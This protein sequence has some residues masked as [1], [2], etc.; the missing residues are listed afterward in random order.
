MKTMK[1]T[2]AF[3]LAF[4]LVAG[5][6]PMTSGNF[7]KGNTEIVAHA[8]YAEGEN[9][10][11]END[12]DEVVLHFKG[13]WDCVDEGY[14]GIENNW[15]DAVSYY[16]YNSPF[17]RTD[18][19]AIVADEGAQLSQSLYGLFQG[20][21]NV[22]T[23][24]LSNVDTTNVTSMCGMFRGMSNLTSVNFG[25]NFNISNVTEMSGMFMD[26]L[27]LTEID[28]S[29]FSNTSKVTYLNQIFQNCTSL[30]KVNFGDF[31]TS[32]VENI[33]NMFATC[34]SLKKIDLS[35]LDTSKVTNSQQVF[36]NCPN[37]EIIT[38]SKKITNGTTFFQ[39]DGIHYDLGVPNGSGAWGWYKD[40]P[41]NIVSGNEE[42]AVIPS[43]EIN[44]TGKTTF[45]RSDKY[46]DGIPSS[47]SGDEGEGGS[48]TGEGTG[49]G[50]STTTPETENKDMTV[51]LDVQ[52]M[53]T[54]TIPASVTL[55]PTS[56]VTESITA[57]NV[58]LDENQKITV[59]LSSASN[60]QEGNVFHAKKGDSSTATYGITVNGQPVSVGGTVAEFTGNGTSSLTFTKAEGA[61]RA[62]RHTETL[63]FTISTSS[64]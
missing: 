28:L 27:S 24:D 51:S 55:S 6:L 7:L 58:M 11:I 34:T 60:T 3:M 46:P 31:N 41:E 12:N 47:G 5:A 56:D 23:V 21:T 10:Y 15:K 13:S 2:I 57:E 63:T 50:G 9:F 45:Y 48:G 8:D 36:Y 39:Q 26:C 43:S 22:K 4:T 54:V 35:F 49:E 20:F 19:T 30:T 17:S 64:T 44:E 16:I 18:I 29:C 32:N 38:V 40:S 52:A 14:E 62:G 37:L 42:Y 1:K 25:D 59:T 33:Q 53:Y 61:T